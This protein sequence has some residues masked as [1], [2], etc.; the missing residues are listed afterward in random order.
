M[1]SELRPDKI[2]RSVQR[3]TIT[4]YGVTDPGPYLFD[5]DY[6]V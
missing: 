6:P 3:M 1:E 5:T 2:S 4:Y